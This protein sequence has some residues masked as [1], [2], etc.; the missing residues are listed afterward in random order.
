MLDGPIPR[1]KT[2]IATIAYDSQSGVDFVAEICIQLKTQIQGSSLVFNPT[3][4]KGAQECQA[5]WE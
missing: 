1:Q 4:L 3:K 2:L 5:S